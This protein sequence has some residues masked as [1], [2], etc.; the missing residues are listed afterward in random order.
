M[1]VHYFRI[2]L[3]NLL[4]NKLYSGINVFGLAVGLAAVLMIF[5]Y[6]QF[7]WSYDEFHA[8]AGRIYRVGAV[9]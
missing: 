1:L 4:K 8:D 3:R 2:A 5:L 9:H 7:E 6:L